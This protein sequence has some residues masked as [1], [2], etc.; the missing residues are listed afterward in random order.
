MGSK[1]RAPIR[2]ARGWTAEERSALMT[3]LEKRAERARKRRA[4]DSEK[5]NMKA[6]GIKEVAPVKRAARLERV[7]RAIHGMKV[8]R[9]RAVHLLGVKRGS[10]LNRRETSRSERREG[11]VKVERAK[12]MLSGRTIVSLDRRKRRVP[13]ARVTT[14][15]SS[16][17]TQWEGKPKR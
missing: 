5:P 1:T 7:R 14:T 16:I 3:L 17:R 8:A 9:E 12:R 10:P 6:L 13:P 4:R 11:M 2:H 15:C